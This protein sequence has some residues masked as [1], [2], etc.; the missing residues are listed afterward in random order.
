MYV[1]RNPIEHKGLKAPKG[2]NEANISHIRPNIT[3]YSIICNVTLDWY[4]NFSIHTICIRVW[5]AHS[6]SSKRLAIII[7]LCSGY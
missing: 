7:I 4:L 6:I 1:L 2:L 3:F 5:H